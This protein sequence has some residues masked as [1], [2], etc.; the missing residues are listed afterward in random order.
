MRRAFRKR[1]R[2]LFF[3]LFVV[4]TS[5]R[6]RV[7]RTS[8]SF[9]R[10]GRAPGITKRRERTRTRARVRGHAKRQFRRPRTPS[11]AVT[12]S[13][14]PAT[15][16]SRARAQHA[17]PGDVPPHGRASAD[18]GPRARPHRCEP[19]RA[20]RRRS[21]LGVPA[22]TRPEALA[23]GRVLSR[24][25]TSEPPPRRGA[26]G[27]ADPPRPR[28]VGARRPARRARARRGRRR[29]LALRARG[30]RAPGGVRAKARARRPERRN[31]YRAGDARR[32]A[33][34]RGRVR[35]A[36]DARGG[37]PRARHR[38]GRRVRVA[39][40]RHVRSREVRR[41]EEREVRVC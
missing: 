13:F 36:R 23:L 30:S 27:P 10:T 39:A 28:G 17:A 38:G 37:R 40:V 3:A 29:G 32:L 33:R 24:G 4:T 11:R 26:G 14:R 21:R 18:G 31:K 5:E 35:A 25:R 20:F 2:T 6:T 16:H 34:R 7:P 9:S 41:R 19:A 12:A 8:S 15:S 22:G 1:C